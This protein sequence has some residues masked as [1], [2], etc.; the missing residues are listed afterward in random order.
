MLTKDLT[1]YPDK[2]YL[3]SRNL[4]V[5]EGV[6]LTIKPGAVFRFSEGTSLTNSG[7]T[8]NCVGTPDSL[9]TFKP[10]RYDYNLSLINTFT[11]K[12][13]DLKY[14]K[15]ENVYEP[16]QCNMTYCIIGENSILRV[17]YL[18]S[19]NRTNISYTFSLSTNNGYIYI[20]ENCNVKVHPYTNENPNINTV[21]SLHKYRYT[22]LNNSNLIANSEFEEIADINNYQGIYYDDTPNYYGSAREDIVRKH[23]YDLNHPTTPTGY[24]V[25]DLS[26]M[27]TRP[28]AEAHGI[29]W[30]L[31]VNGYDAQDEF[32]QLPPLGIGKHKFEVYFNRAM[33][34][35]VIPTVAM[36]AETP[37]N[38]IAI[39][40]DGSW[41]EDGTIYTVYLTID[42]KTGA[43][44]TN[45]IYVA[46]AK[47]DE[48]FEIFVEDSRFNVLVQSAVDQLFCRS[49]S[50]QS[51]THMGTR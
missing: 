34:K 16:E 2:E 48:N 3:V 46:D 24:G 33:N 26:N 44:G 28:S 19:L 45:R 32:E 18:N 14:C 11:L 12:N 6:T 20:A 40:E 49:R 36:G 22:D 1:L 31:V 43:D 7:G 15:I 38:Q 27:L 21:F 25:L 17:D 23:V 47:D 29:V 10:Y 41:N 51:K 50:W 13:L 30:K 42:G 9:I 35:N 8:V 39:D 5:P 4:V 37:Y